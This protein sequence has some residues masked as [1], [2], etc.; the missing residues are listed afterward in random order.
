[1]SFVVNK[2][3][4][5]NDFL[6]IIFTTKLMKLTWFQL[7]FLST[8]PLGGTRL[9]CEASR[10]NSYDPDAHDPDN[11]DSEHKRPD[12]YDTKR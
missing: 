12:T 8:P 10:M 1:M 9:V 4:R 5:M 11:Y 6:F 2:I 7:E 3:E